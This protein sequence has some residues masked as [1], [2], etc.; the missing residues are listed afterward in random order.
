MH[1]LPVLVLQLLK[2]SAL[3]CFVRVAGQAGP[4]SFLLLL[5]LACVMLC[6]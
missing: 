1:T 4:N 6:D 2:L 5:L 3:A